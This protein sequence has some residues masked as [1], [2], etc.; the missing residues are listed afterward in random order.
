MLYFFPFFFRIT[1]TTVFPHC[2]GF[3]FVFSHSSSR[4]LVC[5]IYF[6]VWIKI[7]ANILLLL[8]FRL[9]TYAIKYFGI[10]W[11][12][13]SKGEHLVARLALWRG[14]SLSPF[15]AFLRLSHWAKLNPF[16]NS[17]RSLHNFFYSSTSQT[18]TKIII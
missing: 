3:C 16:I 7:F 13:T 12:H 5:T 8:I 4:I 15:I 9:F 1:S 2:F 18:N 10:N 6:L 17:F 11:C 14:R